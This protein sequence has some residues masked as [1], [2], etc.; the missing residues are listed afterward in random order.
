[1][2]VE[3]QFGK[4]KKVWRWMVLVLAIQTSINSINHRDNV[5]GLT[6]TELYTYKW[7]KMQFLLFV[8]YCNKKLHLKNKLPLLIDADVN[9]NY[10]TMAR[11]YAHIIG[12]TF[13]CL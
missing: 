7:L 9:I 2:S 5:N 3:F 13:T 10:S 11:V 12:I 6:V 8:F 1:M 4:M